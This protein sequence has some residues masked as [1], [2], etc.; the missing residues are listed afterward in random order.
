MKNKH[1]G[2][3]VL[4]AALVGV[5][6]VVHD[7]STKKRGKLSENVFA[8]PEEVSKKV[9]A[10][11]IGYTEIRQLTLKKGNPK[12]FAYADGKIYLL[13]DSMLQVLTPKGE[14]LFTR[15]FAERPYCVAVSGSHVLLGF[16]RRVERYSLSDIASGSTSGVL[17]QRSAEFP[18]GSYIS[19][20][21]AWK[22][23]VYVADAGLK[24]VRV[25]DAT[26]K[27]VA[28]FE[29]ESGVSDQH[30]FI[31]PSMHFELAV[32]ADGELWVVN[33]GLHALQNYAPDGTFRGQWSRSSFETVG[34][35]GCCNP[36]QIAFLPDG[37]FVTAEKGLVRV[38]V[39]KPSG[40]LLTV[41]APPEAFPNA[42]KAPDV[43]VDEMG[44]ILVLDVEQRMLRFFTSKEQQADKNTG[45]P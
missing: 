1:I 42:Y 43:A 25:L 12:A 15:T 27:E 29:G 45:K 31:I 16:E 10:S 38:K 44:T 39:H 2:W 35:S 37:S 26:L 18:E 30:G 36:C 19:A 17:M 32:N 9:E 3:I 11:E 22:D 28:A 8:Y 4:A 14:R 7:L 41:V 13:I 20:I 5:A 23:R 40:E 33:P 24:N 21:A 6:V 34:F